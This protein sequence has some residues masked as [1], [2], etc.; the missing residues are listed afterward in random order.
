VSV[1]SW[2]AGRR[3]EIIALL[4]GMIAI[5]SV[6]GNEGELA[7]FCGSWLGEHGI[8]HHLVPCK[9]RENVISVVGEGDPTLIIA[10]HLDTVPPS[11]GDWAYGPFTPKVV[12][13]KVYGLGASDLHASTVGAYFASLYLRECSLPGRFMTA[14]TIEEET[15][16]DGSR[17]FLDW[18]EREGFLDF[19]RTECVVCEPTDLDLVC[20]G[21]RG[22][23]FVVLTVRGRG[24]H[25]S[26]PHRAKNPLPKLQEILRSLCELEERWARDYPDPEF[27]ATTLT[28]TCVQAG[29]LESTNVIPEYARAVVDCRPTPV[30]YADGLALFREG[31]TE[32]LE[33]A[34]E[35]GFEITWEE[36][37]A[38]EGQKLSEEHPLARIVRG[39][40]REDLGVDASFGVTPAGNDAVFYAAKGI[41]TINK[42]GPGH[43]A[44]AHQ[45]N[46]HVSIEN[47]LLGV[48]LYTWIGLRRFGLEP[49]RGGDPEAHKKAGRGQN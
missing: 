46:E 32:C 17:L 29:D 5:D 35:E 3:E 48:E 7:R 13:G 6:T 11:A 33:R 39:V 25:G 47:L 24:G 10:G 15:T 8:E 21:N 14:F 37:Y 16:G 36:L 4:E 38:R 31:V 22:S 49:G 41:P 26:R 12:E 18:A 9:D 1:R 40:L 45:V 27:G 20:L 44:C 30:L 43:P 34:R 28:P 19:A 23:S 2:V 42:V